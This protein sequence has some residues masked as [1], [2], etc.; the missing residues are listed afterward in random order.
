MP[1]AVTPTA[2]AE[3]LGPAFPFRSNS[4]RHFI[5][6][7]LRARGVS[8]AHVDAMLGHAGFGEQPYAKFS[9]YSPAMLRRA[10]EGP[11]TELV[12][13]MGWRVIPGLN[14]D[15]AWLKR[16]VGLGKSAHDK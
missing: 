10:L 6:T 7:E 12:D 2:L 14:Q 13:E 3:K 5:R 8:G 11:L 1:L 4:Q 9:C 16:L 15:E